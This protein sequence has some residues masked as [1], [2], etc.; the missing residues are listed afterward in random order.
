MRCV[1]FID[2]LE[3]RVEKK[4]TVMALARLTVA[5]VAQVAKWLC[6]RSATVTT[7][8]IKSEC[9][10]R[11]FWAVQSSVAVFVRQL[12]CPLDPTVAPVLVL[13]HI[14]SVDGS[15]LT[16]R[17]FKHLE[18]PASPPLDVPA[19]APL[20]GGGCPL[21]DWF[22]HAP[23]IGPKTMICDGKLTRSQARNV[24]AK[25]ELIPFSATRSYRLDPSTS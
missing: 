15:P 2:H 1:F 17:V 7:L 22:I 21:G 9:R 18:L 10:S 12:C 25:S 11:G 6:E 5:D 16:F 14:E 20:C 8:E 23:S 24:Y 19:V 13:D 3:P 4:H